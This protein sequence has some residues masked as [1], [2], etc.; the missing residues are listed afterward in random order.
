MVAGVVNATRS[1]QLPDNLRIR[2][3]QDPTKIN[4]HEEWEVRFWTQKWNITRDQL[5]TAVRAVGVSTAAVAKF[6]GKQP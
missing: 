4:I 6:L 1:I 5:V 2:R 3:P